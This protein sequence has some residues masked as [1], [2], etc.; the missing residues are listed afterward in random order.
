[1]NDGK[2]SPVADFLLEIGCEEIPARMLAGAASDLTGKVTEVLDAEGLSHG[3][4]RTFC[5]P[6][7]LAVLVRDVALAQESRDEEVTGPPAKASFG[8]DGRPT[9]A[10]LGFA[11]KMGVE[12]S[13]LATIATQKGEYL[14]VRRHVAGRPAAELLAQNLP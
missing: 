14:G 3:D 10:A 1:M 4:A 2:R 9:K 8:A 6:R 7:R 12:V 13:A 11:Q 5:S